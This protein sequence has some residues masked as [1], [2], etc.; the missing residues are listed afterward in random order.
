MKPQVNFLLVQAQAHFAYRFIWLFAAV[1]F[2][3]VVATVVQGG[4]V[5]H[6][7]QLALQWAEKQSRSQA[8]LSESRKLYPEAVR[9]IDLQSQVDTLQ[10]QLDEQQQL[11]AL[12]HS[13]NPVQNTGF[14]RWLEGLSNNARKGIWLTE[15]EMYPAHSRVRLKGM[16][17]GTE[18]LPGYIDELGETTFQGV[19]FGLLDMQQVDKANQVYSFELDS[20]VSDVL[21]KRK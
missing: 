18:V 20:P 14:Y 12:L 16:T 5:Y 21:E 7:Q 9:T 2:A 3:V 11:L 1:V 17:I 10:H 8:E 6:N 15:F 4:L 13:E 19:H